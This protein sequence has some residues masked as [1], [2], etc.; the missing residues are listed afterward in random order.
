MIKMNKKGYLAW[1]VLWEAIQALH[2]YAL[3]VTLEWIYRY[4]YYQ[5]SIMFI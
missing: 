1:A 4:M 3:E 5:G 2:M